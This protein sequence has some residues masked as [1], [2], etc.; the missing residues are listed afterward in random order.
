[1]RRDALEALCATLRVGIGVLLAWCVGKMVLF[2][3]LMWDII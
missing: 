1:M 2:V 3:L